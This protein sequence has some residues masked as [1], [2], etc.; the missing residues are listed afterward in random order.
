MSEK[1]PGLQS[2]MRFY[3]SFPCMKHKLNVD[4]WIAF[5]M[6]IVMLSYKKTLFHLLFGY[7][8]AVEHVLFGYLIE[9]Y[10]ASR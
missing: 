5:V 10:Q 6:F 9:Q 2:W 8:I 1:S 7:D 4:F 3:G